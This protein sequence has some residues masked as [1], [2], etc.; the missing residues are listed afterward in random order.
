[1]PGPLR[2]T[3]TRKDKIMSTPTTTAGLPFITDAGLMA[4]AGAARDDAAGRTYVAGGKHLAAT[5]K[6]VRDGYL[7]EV[8]PGCYALAANGQLWAKLYREAVTALDVYTDVIRHPDGLNRDDRMAYAAWLGRVEGHGSLTAAAIL[9]LFP[10]LGWE[11]ARDWA[12]TGADEMS[13]LI[14]VALTRGEDARR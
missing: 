1:L 9:A 3:T 12:V 10:A 5:R 4:M 6:L 13:T 7:D 2:T 14:H 11:A 8:V